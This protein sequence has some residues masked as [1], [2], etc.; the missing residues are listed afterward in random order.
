V[1]PSGEYLRRESPP[2]R[3]L[4]IPWRRLFLAAFGL[5][6]VVVAVLRDRLLWGWAFYLNYN[7]RGL[8]VMMFY[9]MK[10]PFSY[11]TAWKHRGLSSADRFTAYSTRSTSSL[12]WAS[13]C[14]LVIVELTVHIDRSRLSTITGGT[15]RSTTTCHSGSLQSRSTSASRLILNSF[16]SQRSST[17][18]H[19][20]SWQHAKWRE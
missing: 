9:K 4:A 13:V 14:H 3:M 17:Q 19:D 2:D 8:C 7:K 15:S 16:H 6:L 5:N 10:E 11:L 1:A 20:F 12:G 18:L